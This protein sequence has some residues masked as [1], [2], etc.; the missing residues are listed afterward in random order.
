MF[1]S[2]I[3]VLL[4][5]LICGC[6]G[7][8]TWQAPPGP[9]FLPSAYNNPVMIPPNHP[10]YV[11][12]QVVDVVD[13][14]FR[15]MEEIPVRDMVGSEGRLET[16]PVVGATLLEPWRHDSANFDERLESTLQTIRRLAIISVKKEDCGYLIDVAVYKELEDRSQPDRAVAGSATFSYTATQEGVID[17][18]TDEPLN[19][20]WISLGRDAALE[21]RILSEITSRL[22]LVQPQCAPGG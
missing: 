22:G 3:L 14:Y 19:L 11:W 21:Q 5:V 7:V 6:S 1:R 9:F 4:S 12:E 17:P 13:D 16:F 10:E 18:I 15:I 8:S 20:G 2:F